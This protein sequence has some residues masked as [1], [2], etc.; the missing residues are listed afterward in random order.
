MTTARG[1]GR[2]PKPAPWRDVHLSLPPEVVDAIDRQ[3]EVVATLRGG[4]QTFIA[5]AVAAEL[6][7]RITPGR[8]V[9]A[10][11]PNDDGM[12]E[13]DG[14]GWI[15]RWRTGEIDE[16]VSDIAGIVAITVSKRLLIRPAPAGAP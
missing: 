10:S 2:P 4:R 1:P 14:G 8:Y 9:A 5:L 6:G 13:R 7:R 16:V 11:D 3:P 15:I 12:V